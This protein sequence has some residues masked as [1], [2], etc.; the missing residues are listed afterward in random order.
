MSSEA[1]GRIPDRYEIET[2][3]LTTIVCK[4]PSVINIKGWHFVD[5]LNEGI[6]GG[7][8]VTKSPYFVCYK[9]FPPWDYCVAWTCFPAASDDK[10]FKLLAMGAFEREAFP[11]EEMQIVDERYSF[12]DV[13]SSVLVPEPQHPMQLYGPRVRDI[14]ANV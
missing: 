9:R 8:S 1:N 3:T 5:P 7:A 14:M 4:N 13:I 11:V 12:Y 6:F 10:K 2:H